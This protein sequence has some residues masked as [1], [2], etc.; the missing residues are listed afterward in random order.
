MGQGL[1]TGRNSYD[2]KNQSTGIVWGM[3][4]TII[5]HSGHQA[6]IL[7]TVSAKK[8]HEDT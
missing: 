1:P 5:F 3:Q 2:S 8:W 7:K 4:G 6:E